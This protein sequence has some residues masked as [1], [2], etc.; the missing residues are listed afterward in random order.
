MSLFR[1]VSAVSCYGF[2]TDLVVKHYKEWVTVPFYIVVSGYNEHTNEYE[3]ACFRS[4]KRGDE[5]Y[6]RK[7]LSRFEGLSKTIPN[8]T[9]F[10]FGE[11]DRKKIASPCVFVTLTYDPSVCTI[12]ESWLNA[13]KDLDR[14]ITRLRRRLGKI[15]VVRVFEAHESGYCH[16]HALLY[17]RGR[18]W[19]GFRWDGWKN[20]KRVTKYRVDEVELL[21]AGRRGGFA[22]VLLMSSTKAGFNYLIKYLSKSVDCK[23]EDGKAVK[24]LALSLFFRKRSFSISGHLAQQYSDLIKQLNSNSNLTCDI[25]LSLDGSVV[26]CGVAEWSLHGFVK[27]FV[28]GWGDHWQKVSRNMLV[29]LEESGRIEIK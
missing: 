22:D 12:E 4:P 8:V 28:D 18:S 25:E 19:R 24:T 13:G 5:R 29:E 9:S 11:R 17:F 26:F 16:I 23:A 6:A 2:S 7:L 14:W 10:K 3:Y 20:G 15:S 27:G 1:C 21:K